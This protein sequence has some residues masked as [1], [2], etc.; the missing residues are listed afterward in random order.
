MCF[1]ALSFPGVCPVA[2]EKLGNLN[3]PESAEKEQIMFFSEIQGQRM[4]D[5]REKKMKV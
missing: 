3:S 2:A 5:V 1:C 4:D